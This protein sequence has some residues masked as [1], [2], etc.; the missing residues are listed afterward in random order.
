MIEAQAAS[1]SGL[2]GPFQGL[3]TQEPLNLT[4][5]GGP[6]TS[7]SRGAFVGSVHGQAKSG[8]GEVIG[9]S[10]SM[11]TTPGRMKAFDRASDSERC[12]PNQDIARMTGEKADGGFSYG[13]A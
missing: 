3:S 12:M 6:E 11:L 8:D 13:L 1:T 5:R 2:G 4:V 9:C 10:Y 7:S